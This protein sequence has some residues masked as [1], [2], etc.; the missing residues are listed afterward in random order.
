MPT[1]SVEVLNEFASNISEKNVET[2]RAVLDRMIERYNSIC[3]AIA[4]GAALAEAQVET[5]HKMSLGLA[6]SAEALA[7]SA[8]E[9]GCS[10]QRVALIRMIVAASEYAKSHGLWVECDLLRFLAWGIAEPTGHSAACLRDEFLMPPSETGSLRA[11]GE[12][13]IAAASTML[14]HAVSNL[15][16][17]TR[18]HGGGA[19]KAVAF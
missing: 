2:A 5:E 4:D 17:A 7:I 11:T 13:T 12:R 9:C 1:T 15:A 10:I 8:D 18:Q 3:S 14:A 6:L 19:E 16:L